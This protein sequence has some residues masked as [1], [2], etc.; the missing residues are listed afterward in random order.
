MKQSFRNAGIIA[1]ESIRLV[2]QYPEVRA[3]V[4]HNYLKGMEQVA[5]A[6]VLLITAKNPKIG[7]LRK[8]LVIGSA[9]VA[10]AMS[11][12]HRVGMEV[13]NKLELLQQ[14]RD[15][16]LSALSETGADTDGDWTPQ[17]RKIRIEPEEFSRV[18][19]KITKENMEKGGVSQ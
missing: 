2:K 17:P 10:Y 14:I 3:L 8:G 6:G 11:L 18:L 4:A 5:L 7:L 12:E 16:D 1:K 19:A 9:A 13:D 15:D